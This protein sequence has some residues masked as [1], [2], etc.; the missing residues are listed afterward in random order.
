MSHHDR[1]LKPEPRTRGVLGNIYR[2]LWLV[3]RLANSAEIDLDTA[4]ASGQLNQKD[5]AQ[6]VTRCR[7]SGCDGACAL[8]LSKL[9]PGEQGEVP[10]FCAIY[11]A[12]CCLKAPVREKAR[13]A[14][15]LKQSLE[16]KGLVIR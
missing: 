15:E 3:K 7:A 6:M 5:F 8:H 1:D 10:S 4:L 16:S 12:L 13:E 2:H 9:R 14:Q 11:D